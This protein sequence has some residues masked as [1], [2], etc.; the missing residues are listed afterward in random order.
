MPSGTVPPTPLLKLLQKEKKKKKPKDVF[1]WEEDFAPIP[2][3]FSLQDLSIFH[4]LLWGIFHC[5]CGPRIVLFNG[6]SKGHQIFNPLFHQA[7]LFYFIF[8]H[9]CGPLD[10]LPLAVM[11]TQLPMWLRNLVNRS[12]SSEERE[13]RGK[14]FSEE[15][16]IS[17]TRNQR[18]EIIINHD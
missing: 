17:G 5:L 10:A 1:C 15:V 2:G 3:S 4:L 16:P 13:G 9:S 14:L 12:C 8:W 7:I 18:L 6:L 11:W